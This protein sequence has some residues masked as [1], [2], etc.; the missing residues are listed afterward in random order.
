MEKNGSTGS[1]HRRSVGVIT[2]IFSLCF[3]ASSLMA[4]IDDLLRYKNDGFGIEISVPK[5]WK[6]SRRDLPPQQV[7]TW[8]GKYRKEY[9]LVDFVKEVSG[10][11]TPLLILLQA[12]RYFNSNG[13]RESHGYTFDTSKGIGVYMNALKNQRKFTLVK[14]P[15]RV[16]VDGRTALRFICDL[17]ADR[18]LFTVILDGDDV[19][20]I[21]CIAPV[22][23]FKNNRPSFEKI[24]KS[25]KF[26]K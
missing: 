26:N 10:T 18:I 9:M 13:T 7:A 3:L 1:P 16:S 8:W 19:Q 12:S 21:Q 20:T 14:K 24:L 2:L 6:I 5:G 4:D 22:K 15:Y 23:E 17:D 25:I 11:E